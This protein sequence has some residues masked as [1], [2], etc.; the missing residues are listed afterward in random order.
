MGKAPELRGEPKRFEN[1]VAEIRRIRRAVLLGEPGGG[2]ASESPKNLQKESSFVMINAS[3]D[4]RTDRARERQ[5]AEKHRSL[6]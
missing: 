5:S 4:G 3:E 1:A 6:A 2:A